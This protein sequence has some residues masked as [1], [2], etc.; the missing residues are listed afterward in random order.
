MDREADLVASTAEQLLGIRVTQVACV[1]LADLGDD[2]AAEELA[3]RRAAHLH[4]QEEVED[5]RRSL[6]ASDASN[7][8]CIEGGA[9]SAAALT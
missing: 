3:M 4:L 7:N 2:I 6:G 9:P 5:L 1:V 8:I